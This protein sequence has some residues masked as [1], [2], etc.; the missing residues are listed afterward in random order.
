MK[1]IRSASERVT[2]TAP[3]SGGERDQAR[4]RR[5]KSRTHRETKSSL[6]ELRKRMRMSE[7]ETG[8]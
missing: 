5:K 8:N 1:V 7:G 4:G 6:H 3:L 2:T